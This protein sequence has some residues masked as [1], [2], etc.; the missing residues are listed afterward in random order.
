MTLFSSLLYTI[1]WF[2]CVISGAYTHWIL[3]VLYTIAALLVYFTCLRQRSRRLYSVN[4]LLMVYAGVLGILFEMVYLRLDWI[5]YMSATSLFPP[6]WIICLYLLFGPTLNHAFAFLQKHPLIPPLFGAL[7]GPLSVYAGVKLHAATLPSL[8]MLL[9]LAILWG[10][11][12]SLLCHI[13]KRLLHLSS[14]IFDKKRLNKP[15][16]VLFDGFCSMCARELKH[17][18]TRKQIGKVIYYTITTKEQLSKDFPQIS[19]REAMREIHAFEAT[20]HIL[21]G[22]PVFFELYARVD[23]PLVALLVKAPG[24]TPLVFISYRLWAKFRLTKRP[25]PF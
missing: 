7:G 1:G 8:Y 19:F 13:N 9:P 3:P 15:L 14:Q 6:L 11:Y 21:R 16:T 24:L 17:L 5:S 10:V 4:L 20:G 12:M 22:P 23:L 25:K 18:Q 2:V